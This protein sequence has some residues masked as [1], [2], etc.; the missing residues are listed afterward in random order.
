VPV[1]NMWALRSGFTSRAREKYLLPVIVEEH[2]ADSR[3]G[4]AVLSENSIR[5]WIRIVRQNHR[6]I[7]CDVCDPMRA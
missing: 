2:F 1:L 6:T 5:A 4:W 3:R 7:E